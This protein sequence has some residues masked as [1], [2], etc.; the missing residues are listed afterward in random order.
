MVPRFLALAAA[1]LAAAFLPA[2]AQSFVNNT[3]DIPATVRDTENIDFGD[4]DLDGDWD[5]AL[6]NGG[7]S[8]SQQN[9]LWINQGGLQGGTTGVF[10]DE[11]VPRF[12]SVVDNSRDLEFVDFDGDSDVDVYVADIS[13]IFNQP[14]RWWTNL[15]G[16]QGGALGFFADQTETRWV[17]L[18]GAGSSI[19]PSLLL[20]AGG[21]VD[22]PGDG[23]FADLDGDGDLDLVHSSYGGA[24]SGTVPTRIFLND[25]AG[26]FSEF[27]P[28]GFQLPGLNIS[29]GDPAL[30]CDG[31]QQ[32]ETVDAT[33][34]FADIANAVVDFELGDMDGDFDVDVVWTGRNEIKPRYFV[35]KLNGGSLGFRDVSTEFY[36][37]GFSATSS[38]FDQELG[39]LDDDDDLDLYGLNWTSGFFDVTLEN[40]GGKLANPTTLPGSSQDEEEG[41]FLDYDADGDLDLYVANFSGGDKL[42]R[43]N[44]GNP[45]SFT[46]VSAS[47]LPTGL[48]GI[49]R[50]V[51]TNDVDGDGDYDVFVANSDVETFYV[52]NITQTPDA[53]APRVPLVETVSVAAATSGSVRVRAHV[54]DN[55]AYYTIWYH[56]TDLLVSVDG[57]ALPDLPMSSSRGQVFRG[58]IP[59]NLVGSV[60]YRVRSTDEHGNAGLSSVQ[61]YS[62]T[63][64]TGTLF[65]AES[66]GTALAPPQ[67]AALSEARENQP[68]YVAGTGTLAGGLG[69]LGVSL[70]DQVPPLPVPSLPN[71]ILNIDAGP[72]FLASESCVLDASAKCVAVFDVPGGT[73][74]ADVFFQFVDVAGDGTLGSSKG[75]KLTIQ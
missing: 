30:W 14:S 57:C 12:P 51:E 47:E 74:G 5:A 64:N 6:A 38:T 34:A 46:D 26:F 73:A 15:G 65:G 67:V 16:D 35:N 10:A 7:D 63:G 3:D 4:V 50:D 27:N 37:A 75:L 59:S 56:D 28:S 33:G 40:V 66:A 2:S 49:G 58:E 70:G 18:G 8:G 52:E 1:A 68:L 53:N 54:Y 19:A 62:A 61:G 24:Y 20:P 41:D 29:N 22:F 13:Q 71:L 72:L 48:A 23:D 9:D 44:G 43:N 42:Y 25:G 21:W 69:F 36:P 55:A 45:I 60:Q 17:G 39:D 11:T 32:H 31:V